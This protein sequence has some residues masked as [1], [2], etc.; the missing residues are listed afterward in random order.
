MNAVK[1]AKFKHFP[2]FAHTL[3][4]VVQKGIQKLKT[5]QQKIKAIIEHF[6]RSTTAA[7]KF[8]SLQL[9]INPDKPALKLKNDVL[10]RWNSTYEMFER[11]ANVQ[12]PL[13]LSGSRCT[14]QSS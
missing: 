6:R 12:E 2:C 14:A 5:L 1:L 8:T 7:E 3:N 9:Q 13:E 4:L 10:T 11:I